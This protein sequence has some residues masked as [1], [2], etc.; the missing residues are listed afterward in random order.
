[1]QE[2]Q[3]RE[4]SDADFGALQLWAMVSHGGPIGGPAR[5]L[6]LREWRGALGPW[7]LVISTEGDGAQELADL[8]PGLRAV[9]KALPGRDAALRA[10]VSARMIGLAREWAEDG[11]LSAD[12]LTA[13]LA[14]TEVSV[15]FVSGAFASLWLRESAGI[16]AD[17]VLVA[18]LG[19]SGALEHVSLQG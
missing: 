10:D 19:A 18:E 15:D 4:V 3:I 2:R 8:T 12:T 17:H 16:F 11:A 7:P 6:E 9:L 13:A 14:I 1:M 5:E